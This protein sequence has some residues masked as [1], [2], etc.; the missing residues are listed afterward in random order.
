MFKLSV[1]L[2]LLSIS[3]CITYDFE[4]ATFEKWKLSNNKHYDDECE[5]YH[6]FNIFRKN[7]DKIN[8]Y[9]S[10]N[11]TFTLKLNSFSDITQEEFKTRFIHTHTD[12]NKNILL[13]QQYNMK[14][15]STPDHFD[16]RTVP[17]VVS[18][19]KNQAQCGSCWA[20]STVEALES[21][22]YIKT[23]NSILLSPQE[24]VDCSSTFGNNGCNGGLMT[25][26]F[27]YIIANNGLCSEADIPY[28]A[29]DDVCNL[30]NCK[31][32]YAN[33]NNCYTINRGDQ[34][35]MKEI[36]SLQPISVAIEADTF[37]FQFYSDGIITGQDCGQ[38][39]DHAVVVVGYG[40]QNNIN[41]WIVRNSWGESWGQNGYVLIEKN[42]SNDDDGVCGIGIASSFPSFD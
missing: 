29:I 13:C 7:L 37:L 10:K 28:L 33:I 38:N 40:T 27:E 17:N 4:H 18:P 31:I 26:A 16:W 1:L 8:E 39:I 9:N 34:L 30:S 23:N 32:K 21:L 3:N 35:A 41:Y 14:N 20:F 22:Y 11:N 42:D 6:R 19:V 12:F 36:V 15:I 2:S 24:L 5:N 25:S